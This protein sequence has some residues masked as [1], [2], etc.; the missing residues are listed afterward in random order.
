MAKRI[1]FIDDEDIVL[2]SCRRIFAK[3]DLVLDTAVSG[4]EG[5]DKAR[6]AEFDVVVTDLKMPGLGGMDVLKTL[7]RERPETIVIVFTGY[8]NV[9]T[10]R[11]A[12][13]NGAF[14]YVPKPFTPEEI[15]DVVRNAFEARA[16]K[17]GARM[18]DLMAIVSHE[19]KSPLATVQT[20]AETLYRGYFG[21]L[22]PAQQ[23]IVATILRNCEYLEDVIRSY[24]DLSKMEIDDLDAFRKDIRLGADVVRP[25]IEVPEIKANLKGM[26]VE[27]DLDGDA[28]VTGDPELL[29]IVVRNL[30]NN[31]IKYGRDGTPV[32]IRIELRGGEAVL[33][34]RNE[35][36]GISAEDLRGRLFKRFER[37]K[38]KGTEGVKG[39]GLGLYICRKIVEKH[40]GRIWA[41]S[42]P[43]QGAEFFVALPLSDAS[44]E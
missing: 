43:G 19:L 10:A 8:A 30:V 18:L 31:A 32:R 6:A 5:L 24:I 33:S 29:K 22:D 35:G 2:R 28:A 34:V 44:R 12:L 7:R 38:Q 14:D 9:E 41:E 15:K 3:E 20:T 36:V 21:K 25:V 23:K 4:E 16:K 42:E 1:L 26:A 27:A 13:K 37:L 39:S 17:S 11:E 40:R